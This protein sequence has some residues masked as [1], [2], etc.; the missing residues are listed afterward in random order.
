LKR[1]KASFS[2]GVT[3]RLY[4]VLWQHLE[5][6]NKMQVRL[7]DQAG[8]NYKPTPQVLDFVANTS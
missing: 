8:V 5:Y 4:I 1:N 7:R 2:G 3:P 6:N